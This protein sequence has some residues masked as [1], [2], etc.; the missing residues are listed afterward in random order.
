MEY[1]LAES[2]PIRF[3][4]DIHSKQEIPANYDANKTVQELYD[5]YTD[6]DSKMKFRNFL[7]FSTSEDISH[8]F[9]VDNGFY[10]QRVSQVSI[11]H[12]FGKPNPFDLQFWE[13]EKKYKSPYENNLRFFNTTATRQNQ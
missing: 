1:A 6:N 2:H 3:S 10:L 9:Y 5:N 13:L 7:T 8:K 4:K 11:T 12:F